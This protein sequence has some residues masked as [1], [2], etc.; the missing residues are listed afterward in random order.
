M[1]AWRGL[2]NRA[3]KERLEEWMLFSLNKKYLFWKVNQHFPKWRVEKICSIHHRFDWVDL[4]S[5]QENSSARRK[6]HRESSASLRKGRDVR[7]SCPQA[8]DGTGELSGSSPSYLWDCRVSMDDIHRVHPTR[9]CAEPGVGEEHRIH[10]SLDNYNK[11]MEGNTLVEI[12]V[13][14]M[15]V[16]ASCTVTGPTKLLPW[17]RVDD[18]ASILHMQKD[19]PAGS[20]HVS[21]VTGIKLKTSW[22][23]AHQTVWKTGWMSPEPKVFLKEP[24]SKEN[25]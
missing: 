24:H 2:E 10:F 4:V 15:I 14:S 20:E 23:L 3:W 21:R 18:P 22:S 16:Y 19:E 25:P 17:I 9:G 7:G 8:G 13:K 11:P 12:T 6:K 5:A 1:T